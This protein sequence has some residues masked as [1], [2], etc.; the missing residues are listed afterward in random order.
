M[1]AFPIR[2]N[3]DLERAIALVTDVWDA[4]PGSAEAD[5]LEVMSTLIDA[6]EA[7]HSTLPHGDP[8][9]LIEFKLK[10]H[11]WT[12]RDLARQLD[13]EIERVSE[14]LNRKSPLTL[15]VVRQLSRVLQIPPGLLVNGCRGPTELEEG[16]PKKGQAQCGWR[17][18]CCHP[19]CD[20]ML[21]EWSSGRAQPRLPYSRDIHGWVVL[22]ARVLRKL[23]QCRGSLPEGYVLAYC[24]EHAA[25]LR[26][27]REA[28]DR[29][30]DARRA[31]VKQE[32]PRDV[33]SRVVQ[34]LRGSF[35][36]KSLATTAESRRKVFETQNPVP[37]FPWP[38]KGTP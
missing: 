4:P 12:Q 9:R 29:W 37:T 19:N 25:P 17:V 3:E 30:D 34:F 27:F 38:W 13:W 11:G 24:P 2:N 36:A 33:L 21:M 26:E 6:Y 8:V 7:S 22:P 14:I 10:E 23:E 15:E 28:Y 18:V 32:I 20:A 35:A 1:C 16:K 31:Y 5:L